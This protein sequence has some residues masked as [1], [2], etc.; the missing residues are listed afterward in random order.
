MR[1]RQL[2][3]ELEAKRSMAKA[4][5]ECWKKFEEGFELF[6]GLFSSDLVDDDQEDA[7]RDERKRQIWTVELSQ[8]GQEMDM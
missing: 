2:A 8:H 3:H 7:C 5:W 1:G 4:D 6:H